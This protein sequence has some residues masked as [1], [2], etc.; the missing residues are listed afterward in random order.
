[1]SAIWHVY[2]TWANHLSASSVTFF[3][4]ASIQGA[5]KNVFY[6]FCRYQNTLYVVHVFY[7]RLG[8][9]AT[10]VNATGPGRGAW[11]VLVVVAGRRSRLGSV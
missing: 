3:T 9:A 11:A 10:G 8:A 2:M 7:R 4:R 6:V 1:M 5:V